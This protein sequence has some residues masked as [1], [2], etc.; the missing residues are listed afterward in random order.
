LA[1][2][3]LTV[4]VIDAPMFD[5]AFG[6]LVDN[7][8]EGRVLAALDGGADGIAFTESN[9]NRFVHQ[10]PMQAA[11]AATLRLAWQHRTAIIH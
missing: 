6:G 3:L 10:E 2:D 4:V 11:G 5:N 1:T 8:D 7:N 9:I